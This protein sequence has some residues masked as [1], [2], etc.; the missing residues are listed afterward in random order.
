MKKVLLGSTALAVA[1][2]V[3]SVAPASAQLEV[4]VTGYMENWVGY[5]NQD[6]DTGDFDGINTAQDTEIIFTGSSTLD[7]GLTFGVNV[8]LEGNTSGD[9]IDESYMFARGSFGEI[10]L[11]DE[12]SA[13]YKMQYAAPDV[14][15]GFNSGDTTL[16]VNPGQGGS[17]GTT[18]LYRG[19]FGSTFVEVARL[20]DVFRITYFT[21]RFSGFQFGAS[22]APGDN[23]DSGGALANNRDNSV[24][25]A[26]SFGANYV[27]SFDGIDVAVSGGYGT[28]SCDSDGSTDD[29][30]VLTQSCM[31]DT[32]TAWNAGAQ[33]SFSGVTIGGSYAEA[34]D[35]PAV[36][37]MEGFDLGISYGQ[38]PWSASATY[39]HG[40]RDLADAEWDTIHV[41]GRYALGPGID[42][43]G[44]VGWAE[45]EGEDEEDVPAVLAVVE[46]GLEKKD[47]CT[48]SKPQNCGPGGG[49]GG[50][51]GGEIVSLDNE[52]FF[53]VVGPAISF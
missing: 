49:G 43:V 14:G 1:G 51:G 17:I 33:V 48:P 34:S 39:Y 23:E 42:L 10:L 37:D 29:D 28:A 40:E 44:T 16:W 38:G 26:F 12:N 20:N 45:F 6:D 31:D 19:A 25:D 21:P 8:Q 4:G 46:G 50:S 18:G 36:G 15:I 32:T 2:V 5:S 30:G 9:Q 22:Y 52:G 35:D 27:E 53:V 3:A 24:H 13:Q 47:P 11:G 7:N 41:S